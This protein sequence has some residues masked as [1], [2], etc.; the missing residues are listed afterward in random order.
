MVLGPPW[1]ART[2]IAGGWVQKGMVTVGAGTP[3]VL[4]TTKDLP[5]Q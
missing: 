5:G 1:T 3:G 4:D 2:G